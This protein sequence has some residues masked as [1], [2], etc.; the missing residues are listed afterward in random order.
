MF[1]HNL[2]L[3]EF[4]FARDRCSVIVSLV[5]GRL[6]VSCVY[7]FTRAKPMLGQT[8]GSKKFAGRVGEVGPSKA[9]V[10][11]REYLGADIQLS[12]SIAS[13]ICERLSRMWIPI[14]WSC[15]YVDTAS[16][17]PAGRRTLC[18]YSAAG[19]RENCSV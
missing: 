9:E 1:M 14:V 8:S 19:S 7:G 16:I 15:M 17:T 18:A 3:W 5:V 11:P 4:R 12:R 2:W 10:H 13:V 6:W